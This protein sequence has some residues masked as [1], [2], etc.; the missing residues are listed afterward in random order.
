MSGTKSLELWIRGNQR[1]ILLATQEEVNKSL[2]STPWKLE[3]LGCLPMEQVRG[4]KAKRNAHVVK[5][6]E[7]EA[8]SVA[9][10]NGSEAIEKCIT[11][12]HERLLGKAH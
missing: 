12:D 3:K 10:G 6:D 1:I 4:R 7:D 11:V 5:G 9:F 2:S 8:P